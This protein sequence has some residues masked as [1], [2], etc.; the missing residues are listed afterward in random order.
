MHIILS[1][2]DPGPYVDRMAGFSLYISNTTSKDEGHCCSKDNSRGNP[3]VNQSINCSVYGRY[4]IYYNEHSPSNNPSF[5][6][7]YAYNELCEVEVYGEY[8]QK[9]NILLNIKMCT[10]SYLFHSLTS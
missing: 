4:V 3:S 9:L 8:V 10:N 7:R 5:L 6:S 2:L 1:T